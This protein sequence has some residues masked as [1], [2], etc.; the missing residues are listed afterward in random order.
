MVDRSNR[1]HEDKSLSR[2]AMARQNHQI[3]VIF[4]S[5]LNSRLPGMEKNVK[6]ETIQWFIFSYV[7][8]KNKHHVLKTNNNL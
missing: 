8:K 1:K 3:C 4:C 5:S 7:K 6:Q 2:T